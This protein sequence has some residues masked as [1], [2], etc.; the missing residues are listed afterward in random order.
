MVNVNITINLE[1]YNLQEIMKFITLAL[2]SVNINRGQ[3]VTQTY[4]QD[5]LFAVIVKHKNIIRV[6]INQKP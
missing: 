1:D 2:G 4:F 5:N 3:S 6:S